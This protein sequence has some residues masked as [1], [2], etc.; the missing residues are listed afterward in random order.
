[1]SEILSQS[2][3]DALLNSLQN[4]V[5]PLKEHLKTEADENEYR[6]YDFY[7]PK[8]FTKDKLRLLESIYDNY[9]TNYPKVIG[10]LV[11]SRY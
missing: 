4:D 11:Q 3:I 7:S 6:K 2:Q 8:K 10:R 9:S 5:S 1:M